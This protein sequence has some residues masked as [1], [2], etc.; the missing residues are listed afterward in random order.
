MFNRTRVWR[1][2]IFGIALVVL[3]A[4]A[5]IVLFG[6]I[7]SSVPTGSEAAVVSVGSP[8]PTVSP[9]PPKPLDALNRQ[10]MKLRQAQK[11][12]T[13]VS[14]EELT[15][16]EAASLADTPGYLQTYDRF[17]QSPPQQYQIKIH[18]T[19]F[20]DRLQ[21]DRNGRPV[22]NKLL[23]VLHE[24]TGLASSAVNA[25]LTPHPRD[26][27][28]VSYHAIVR[29]DGAIIYLV[30]PLQRA[31]GAGNSAFKGLRGTETVQTK[32]S[33]APSVN[34]FAYH[35]SLETPPDGYHNDPEHSGYTTAQYSSLAWLVARSGVE[36]E[37]IVTHA[38]VDQSG[39]RQDPRS[40]DM[41]WLRQELVLQS[42][43]NISLD[44][45][46]PL[47]ETEQDG[48]V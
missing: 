39:E 27:D 37:R 15:A 5:T 36:T 3:S 4:W 30:D 24:T 9:L 13:L 32:K 41:D 2:A 43:I 22:Q 40:L 46:Q 7:Y 48:S 31:Y 20:G 21:R 8:L 47:P 38:A 16:Q 1:K 17:G 42:D 28:Q 44:L 18:A 23:V 25:M 29:R 12:A 34:N 6:A 33:L 11:A 26:A 19:N 14:V 10:L 45:E 35:I